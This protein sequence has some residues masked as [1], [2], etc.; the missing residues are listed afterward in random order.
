M[1]TDTDLAASNLTL[2]TF[3]PVQLYSGE[4]PPVTTSY[5]VED[6][7]VLAKYEVVALNSAGEVCAW[8]PMAYDTIGDAYATGTITFSGTGTAADTITLNGTVIT[9]RGGDAAGDDEFN[10]GASATLSAQAF[11]TL[12][13]TYPDVYDVVA[14]GGAAAITLTR[15]IPGTAGNAYTTTESGTGASFGA[16]TL[17]GGT[18]IVVK[19]YKGVPIGITM[20]AC[21]NTDDGKSVPVLIEGVLNPDAL[22]WPDVSEN[23]A[24]TAASKIAAFPP[25]SGIVIRPLK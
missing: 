16:A 11:K 17:T 3:S 18:D 15:R 8:D 10:I 2:G 14:T 21:D 23:F 7:A 5:V 20:Q 22:V 19:R 9:M 4:K 12:V 1:P 24:G 13:N 25:G 6:T